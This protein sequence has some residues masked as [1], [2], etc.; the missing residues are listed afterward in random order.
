MREFVLFGAITGHA[1]NHKIFGPV[2]AAAGQGYNVVNVISIANLSTAV[3]AFALLG[4]VL[5]LDIIAGMSALGIAFK[6]AAMKFIESERVRVFSF[7]SAITFLDARFEFYTVG[8]ISLPN[9]FWMSGTKRASLFANTLL[10][11]LVI[12]AGFL[13]NT[14]LVIGAISRAAFLAGGFEFQRA[15]TISITIKVFSCL[16]LYLAALGAS[17]KGVVRGIMGMHQKLAF[18]LPSLGLLAQSPGTL[19]WFAPVSISQAGAAKQ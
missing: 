14:F 19:H 4:F 2:R 3:V 5:R 8:A 15:S 18:L 1:R 10:V 13:G 11:G 16:W 6:C 12:V 17:L 9:E 7:P